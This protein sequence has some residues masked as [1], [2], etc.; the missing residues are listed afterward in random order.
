MCVCGVCSY[1]E[2]PEHWH[3]GSAGP[4]GHE[5][6]RCTHHQQWH[7]HRPQL[8]AEGVRSTRAPVREPAGCTDAGR[9]TAA[10]AD[11]AAADALHDCFRYQLL[12]KSEMLRV[13]ECVAFEE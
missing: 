10:H 7:T 6:T 12:R 13:I 1:A 5:S 2:L 9:R 4:R 8:H 3:A 11:P